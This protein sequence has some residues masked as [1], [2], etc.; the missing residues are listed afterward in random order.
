MDADSD[1]TLCST[2]G[3]LPHSL[4]R[5]Y[6]RQGYDAGAAICITIVH[7]TRRQC[8]SAFRP[9]LTVRS[10]SIRRCSTCTTTHTHTHTCAH[11]RPFVRHR[12]VR[13][14]VVRV[15][16]AG[17]PSVAHRSRPVRAARTTA[18]A[19]RCTTTA[20]R[21]PAKTAAPSVRHPLPVPCA[22]RS[23]TR[24]QLAPRIRPVRWLP[25]NLC[26]T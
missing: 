22:V 10:R 17:Y 11:T 3:A 5:S 6:K 8:C 18:V 9:M 12:C 20:Q 2:S 1:P 4:N 7:A 24:A 26:V 15:P 21:A 16:A 13:V 14:P 19:Q 23:A 25:L